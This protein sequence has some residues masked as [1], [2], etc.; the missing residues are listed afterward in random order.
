MLTNNSKM[1]FFTITS[2]SC[3][4]ITS[5]ERIERTSLLIELKGMLHRRFFRMRNCMM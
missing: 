1:F 2:G 3:Q 5:S 4:L